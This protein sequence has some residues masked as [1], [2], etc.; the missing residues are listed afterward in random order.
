MNICEEQKLF[1]ELFQYPLKEAVIIH[2]NP[3]YLQDIELVQQYILEELN[4]RKVTL[5]LDKVKYGVTLKA[6]PDHKTLGAR[7]KSEFKD[8]M[9]D[10][11]VSILE[12][13]N[14]WR[15]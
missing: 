5:S 10:I 2:N 3:K 13:G 11:K 1:I 4:V 12:T 8:I 15:F 6:E 7:L 14:S 9:S